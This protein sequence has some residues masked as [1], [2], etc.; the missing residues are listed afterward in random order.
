M[1]QPD[2][3]HVPPIPGPEPVRH[4]QLGDLPDVSPPPG[5]Y[6]PTP[7]PRYYEPAPPPGYYQ[8]APPQGGY[9]PQPT[10][11]MAILGLGFAFLFSP[12]GIA[13]SIVGLRQ[14]ERRQEKGH[15]LAV[16]G[17]VLSVVFLVLGIFLAVDRV[18]GPATGSEATAGEPRP[19]NSPV[20]PTEDPDGVLAACR[21]IQPA[22]VRFEGELAA[23]TTAEEYTAVMNAIRTTMESAAA[24]ATDPEFVAHVRQ[25]S[26]DFE[27]LVAMV[28]RGEDPSSLEDT[29]AAHGG[30]IDDDCAAAGYRE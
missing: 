5:Y 3:D 23:V 25:F 9:R 24:D 22:F 4:P 13:F 19:D 17:L 14:V 7:R 18:R 16:T 20:V 11:T 6:E 21:I 2:H 15:G 30:A 27:L 8:P 12:L 29:V 26:A 10:N 1:S 28:G